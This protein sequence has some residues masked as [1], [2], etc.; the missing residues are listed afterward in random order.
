MSAFDE[1]KFAERD[2]VHIA[3]REVVG[4]PRSDV[5]IVLSTGQFIP[6][7][8]MWDDRVHA[9]FLDGLGALGRLIVYDRRGLGLSDPIEEWDD[10]LSVSWADDVIAV[11][12]DAGVPAAHL[13][14]WNI[15]SGTS[16]RVAAEHPERVRSLVLFHGA[17]TAERAARLRG[18]SIADMTE[19]MVSWVQGSGE[20]APLTPGNTMNPSRDG[21]A[22]LEAWL[23]TA[24]RR[25]ASP[26]TAARIWRVVLAAGREVDLS[27][28]TSPALVLWRRG[29]L[30][31]GDVPGGGR[32]MAGE[33]PNASYVE[34]PGADGAPYS[35]DVDALL[36]EIR[37]FITGDAGESVVGD[38]R[39]AAVLFSDIVDSTD[40]AATVGDTA[41]RGTLDAH[42]HLAREL[43]GQAG[44]RVVKHTGDGVL[45][46]FDL[47]SQAVIAARELHDRLLGIGL[48]VRVGIHVGEVEHRGDDI[49]G[50]AVHAASRLMALAGPNETV[51]SAAVPLVA[52]LG[53]ETCSPGPT[54]ELR[55]LPGE[56]ATFRLV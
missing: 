8:C 10:P 13:V 5:V 9:R 12:D 54:V 30:G 7:E 49:A 44:G 43:V 19:A 53:A 52:G 23:R 42:D 14:G 15:G 56:W 4:D 2:G 27:A 34:M 11:M 51:T 47:A 37:R 25:G 29:Y 31:A 41:W 6:I 48:H 38:R 3:Y 45:A 39:I 22:S 33:L 1:V 36:V 35:G 21:D 17:D 50:V 46:E 40:T 26:A 28:V 55:G 18:M 20:G 16:V 32:E 24:G